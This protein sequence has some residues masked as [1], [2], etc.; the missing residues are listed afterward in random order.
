MAA[1]KPKSKQGDELLKLLTSVVNRAMKNG[2][3]A[4]VNQ[5]VK[6]AAKKAASPKVQQQVARSMTKRRAMAKTE[7]MAKNYYGK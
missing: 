4:L 1:K 7:K 5:P 6:K 3:P 2:A